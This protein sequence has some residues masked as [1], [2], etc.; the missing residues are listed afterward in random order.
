[1]YPCT[2]VGNVGSTPEMRYTPNG[3]EVVNFNF[4]CHGDR[5]KEGKEIPTWYRVTC[6]SDLAQVANK[7]IGVGDHLMLGGNLKP[8]NC[9]L[10]RDKKTG[11]PIIDD[12]TGEPIPAASLEFTAFKVVGLTYAEVDLMKDQ[13]EEGES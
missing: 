5:D 4:A 9:Y 6:W 11:K 3:K 2:I 1:M 10:K 7:K 12:V 8:P 13:A